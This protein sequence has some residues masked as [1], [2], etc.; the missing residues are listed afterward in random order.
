MLNDADTKDLFNEL[1][2]L[3]ADE[4]AYLQKRVKGTFEEWEKPWLLRCFN[5]TLEY[6][7]YVA[8]TWLKCA[9]SLVFFPFSES[10][11]ALTVVERAHPL[12][13]L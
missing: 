7:K 12:L 10:V 13:Q 8:E 1:R 6:V 11:C 9:W 3:H 5:I 4:F 2:A